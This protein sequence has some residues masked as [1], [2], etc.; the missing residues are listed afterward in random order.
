MCRRSLIA[1]LGDLLWV[2]RCAACDAPLDGGAA[3]C[4]PCALSLA[5]ALPPRCPRC[6]LSFEGAGAD[7]LCA[8]CLRSPPPFAALAARFAYGGALADAIARFKYG[9]APHLAA[10]LSGLLFEGYAPPAVDLV[11]PVPLHPR[12]LRRRG[13]NQAALLLGGAPG[14]LLSKV[15][16]SVLR[17]IEDTPHQAGLGRRERLDALAGAFRAPPSSKLRD[18]RVLLVDDVATTTATLRAAAAALLDGGARE[19]EALCLAR[20]M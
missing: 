11:V 18:A 10:P 4:P 19:V 16:T 14:S 20:A 3:F 8:G 15:S 6:G 9:P 12:R 17:R 2:P 13:F 5:P 1:S 7:H